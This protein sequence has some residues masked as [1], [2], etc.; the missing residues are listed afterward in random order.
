MQHR[1]GGTRLWVAALVLTLTGLLAGCG[2]QTTGG[3]QAASGNTSS[4][5][6]SSK[7]TCVSEVKQIN[8]VDTRSFCGSTSAQAT[9]GGQ[10]WSW[11]NGECSSEMGMFSVNVGRVILGTGSAADDLKKQ[12]DYFG[13]AVAATADGT[14][15]GTA[16]GHYQGHLFAIPQAQIT[17]SDNL[18]KGTFSGKSYMD[19]STVTGSWSC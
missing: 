12:Y 17:L 1:Q 10:P 14:Y 19:G 16:D 6:G 18:H 8:G 7:S 9:V 4:S 3:T 11:S 13:I 2:T 5:G 15:T